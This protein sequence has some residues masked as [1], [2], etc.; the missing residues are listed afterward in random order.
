MCRFHFHTFFLLA[1]QANIWEGESAYFGQIAS[2]I[3]KTGL[4]QIIWHNVDKNQFPCL[5]SDPSQEIDSQFGFSAYSFFIL[6]YR[7][8]V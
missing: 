3:L 1:D 2:I 6:P 8:I 7:V 4:S 5:F